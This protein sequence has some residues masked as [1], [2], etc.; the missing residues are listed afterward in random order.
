MVFVNSARWQASRLSLAQRKRVHDRL[1]QVGYTP[2]PRA[3]FGPNDTLNQ[4]QQPIGA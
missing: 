4:M 1:W 2:C 3:D